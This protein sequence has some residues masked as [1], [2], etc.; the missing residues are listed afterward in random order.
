M[1]GGHKIFLSRALA[2]GTPIPFLMLHREFLDG[3]VSC[4]STTMFPAS[5]SDHHWGCSQRG[6][7]GWDGSPW[8][9]NGPRY[10][11]PSF[12]EVSPH[13]TAQ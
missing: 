9:C 5:H 4:W 1:L 6:E 8:E 10:R 7:E 3:H 13:P 2:W 11:L 12:L